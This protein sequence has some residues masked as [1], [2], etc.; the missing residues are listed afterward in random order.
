[1][2]DARLVATN[3]ENSSI[4]PVACNAAGQV[5][6][7]DVVI[8]QISNDLDLDGDLTVS[9]KGSFS[10]DISISNGDLG[11]SGNANIGGS[12]VAGDEV[13]SLRHSCNYKGGGTGSVFK[14]YEGL[15]TDDGA[16]P[17]ISLNNDGSAKFAGAVASGNG[18][19]IDTSVSAAST[20]LGFGSVYCSR[21][22]DQNAVWRGR[23][24]GSLDITSRINADGSTIFANGKAGFTAE[25]YLWCT[26]ERGDTVYLQGT[27]N[28]VGLWAAYTPVTRG[29]LI[30]EKVQE[31][32]EK[33]EPGESQER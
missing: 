1:M 19:D 21:S 12:V 13:T 5:L 27:S 8:E 25:G 4:V 7:S 28:G 20:V 11:V 3:P 2:T 29:D 30:K 23:E 16:N 32:S 6:V 22:G 31:W 33:K 24:S 14:I 10:S 18:R 17:E 15:Q 9:G 26:T